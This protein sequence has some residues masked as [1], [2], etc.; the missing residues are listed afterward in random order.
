MHG[1]SKSETKLYLLVNIAELRIRTGFFSLFSTQQTLDF[2]QSINQSREY[3]HRDRL[4]L[5][6]PC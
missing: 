6:F 4:P 1:L 3:G 5:H 2:E